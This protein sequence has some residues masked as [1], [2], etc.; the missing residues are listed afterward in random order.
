MKDRKR[1]HNSNINVH[2]F[3]VHEKL[4][5][6]NGKGIKLVPTHFVT[7]VLELRT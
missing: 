4:I 6:F 3:S 1:T 7:P 2:F 5:D